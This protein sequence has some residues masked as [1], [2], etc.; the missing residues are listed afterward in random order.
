MTEGQKPTSKIVVLISGSGSNLQSIIN[1][2]EE[3]NIDAQISAVIS[4]KY[5]VK[6]LDRAA[7]ANIPSIVID[8]H[9]F[10]T[11]QAFDQHLAE[12][13]I[14][15]TPDLIILAGFMRI[16]TEEFVNQ[17]VGKLINIHPSLLPAYPG[18]NTH[19]RAIEAGDRTAGATV[20]FVTPELDGGPS[21]LRAQVAVLEND[22]SDALAARVLTMEHQI[23]PTVAQ[24]F[25]E[26]RIG[27]KDGIVFFDGV[28]IDKL[29]LLFTP[30]SEH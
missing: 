30:Q 6:G 21:I 22:T 18:L 15:F 7:A 11:R 14:G 3:N 16:F 23:Y 20:H 2:C 19:Q 25:C 27:M 29:G 12:V 1:A 9:A 28:Q 8:H 24:W 13:I 10:E 5:N 4:N 26:G 17:F